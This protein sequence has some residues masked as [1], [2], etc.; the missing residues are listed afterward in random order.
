MFRPEYPR[1]S[2]VRDDWENLNGQWDF[3]IGFDSSNLDEVVFDKKIE[4]PFCPESKLSGIEHR[5]FMSSVWYKRTFEITEEQKNG[6]VFMNF[7]AADYMTKVWVNGMLVGTHK[8]GYTT[9]SFEITD[10]CTVGE[11][12][13]QIQCLD[14]TKNPEIATGKQ[15][16]W[17][18]SVGC[19]Y[20]RTTGIWQTV[21]LEFVGTSYTFLPRIVADVDTKTITL[22][23]KTKNSDG[24]T[25]RAKA[26]YKGEKV[27]ENEMSI[28]RDTFRLSLELDDIKLWDVFKAEIY[29]IEITVEKDGEA[30]DTLKTY[31]AFRKF[32]LKNKKFYLNDRPIFLRQILDQG[33][34][35]DGVYTAPTAEAI[36]KDIDI[37]IS[38]GY[39][40]ARLHQKVFEERFFYYA[41]MKGYLVWGEF[42]SWGCNIT[43]KHMNGVKQFISEWLDSVARDMNHPSIIGWCP[44]NEVWD[45]QVN[46]ADDT[47]EKL[48]YKNTRALDPT[49]CCIG[50]S[51]G[52]LFITD[53]DDYHDYS[54]TGDELEKSFLIHNN[55]TVN[56][57]AVS[58]QNKLYKKNLLTST[59]LQALP[60][61]LSEYG[62]IRFSKK[63]DGWGYVTETDEKSFIDRYC[64]LTDRC[65]HSPLAGICYT[66][67]TDVE[68]EQNGLVTYEREMKVSE[69]GRQ[70]MYDCM[71]QIADAERE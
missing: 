9:F 12:T 43:K 42:P 47:C 51:G 68:Q 11:N 54:P 13:V 6:T 71:A 46:D 48:I 17:D 36:E 14:D 18:D 70:R 23:G 69:E 27:A 15:S 16:P 63:A 3:S 19:H 60:I 5:D 24:L 32:E 41:D 33:F 37:A 10:A 61:F 53:V 38:F 62:G 50:A 7:G 34:Y 8:G 64:D 66:Q 28:V 22:S 2:F 30:V 59:Q 52:K 49:R 39:N 65:I 55:G 57:K 4:V 25:F 20:T 21:W 40:G 1:P 58:V 31:T 44:L 67:L 56:P 35:P 26:L 29:D 45:R